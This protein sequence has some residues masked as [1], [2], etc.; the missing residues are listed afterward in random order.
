M[1]LQHALENLSGLAVSGVIPQ[2]VVDEGRIFS[3]GT[4][5]NE[6]S[7]HGR[8]R[9]VVQGLKDHVGQ[10][11]D[12]QAWAFTYELSTEK[13]DGVK[14]PL[15]FL[16]IVQ[17]QANEAILV[18]EFLTGPKT[19]RLINRISFCH[20]SAG[21]IGNV[22][23]ARTKGDAEDCLARSVYPLAIAIL[24]TRGCSV[25][26]RR[27]PSVTNARR[28]RRGKP[29]I[30]G[31]HD[32]DATEY[33]TALRSTSISRDLGGT[34]A[35]PLPHLRRAHERVLSDGRRIWVRSALINVRAEGD[36]AFVERRKAYR[37]RTHSIRNTRSPS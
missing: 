19:P 12:A 30:P 1:K 32:V 3:F 11:F 29:I 25:T 26:F 6:D 4:F 31:H 28:K 8:V 20:T 9:D 22:L 21:V 17:P 23:G 35:S 14:P 34:H 2:G 15:T 5:E 13:Q 7:L 27:A 24:N 10:P 37:G 16:A 36:I 18:W 33:V